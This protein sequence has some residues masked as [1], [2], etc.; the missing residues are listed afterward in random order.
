[1]LTI[2]IIFVSISILLL[3]C[4]TYYFLYYNYINKRLVD[5]CKKRHL[6]HPTTTVL[7]LALLFSIMFN[8]IFYI[9]L[10]SVNKENT[11]LKFEN[12]NFSKALHISEIDAQSPYS[13][14]RDI[15]TSND[16][17]GYK[18]TYTESND[19]H[20][21]FA[22]SE[23]KDF[24]DTGY[25]PEYICYI[26]YDGVLTKDTDVTIEYIYGENNSH[27]TTGELEREIMLLG[28]YLERLPQEV[29][30]TIRERGSKL[31]EGNIIA[32]ASFVLYSI[33]K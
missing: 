33:N 13:F 15:I 29:K 20:F 19:F 3:L 28:R 2:S 14:Y 16:S 18:V 31:E 26:K 12:N 7:Y 32:N 6:P 8:V 1:M 23:Y 30:I 24:S 22:H 27:S 4:V 25:Y 11:S 10:N 5:K 21:Y 17:Y 9:E